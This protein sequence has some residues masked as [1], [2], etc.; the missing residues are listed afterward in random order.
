MREH[1]PHSHV[2]VKKIWSYKMSSVVVELLSIILN[3]MASFHIGLTS[4]L[5]KIC[6]I[7]ILDEY[8]LMGNWGQVHRSSF[9]V[10][11][12]EELHNCPD[13]SRLRRNFYGLNLCSWMLNSILFLF[14]FILH[15]VEFFGRGSSMENSHIFWEIIWSKIPITISSKQLQSK[16]HAS[17]MYSSLLLPGTSSVLVSLTRN[18]FGYSLCILDGLISVQ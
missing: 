17:S 13:L 6:I 15:F 12:K 9:E 5:E 3:L 2:R 4:L 1:G 7:M 16:L 11:T 18:S 10:S 14:G 8:I